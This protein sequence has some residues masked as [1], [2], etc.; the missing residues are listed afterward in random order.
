MTDLK[1]LAALPATDGHIARARE[2]ARA[3]P[4]IRPYFEALLASNPTRG[5]MVEFMESVRVGAEP[6]FAAQQLNLRIDA[7][8]K[9][10]GIDAPTGTERLMAMQIGLL[11]DQNTILQNAV[12]RSS[13]QAPA[14]DKASTSSGSF[15]ALLGGMLLGAALTR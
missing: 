4:N 8:C 10:A 3:Y 7:I 5:Q 14:E 2:A 6:V 12:I 9:A 1:E 13:N 11:Q 15:T